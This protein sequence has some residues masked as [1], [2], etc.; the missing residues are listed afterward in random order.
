MMPESALRDKV[1]CICS[2]PIVR[3]GAT[4]YRCDSCN[5]NITEGTST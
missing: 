4:S 1:C 3:T 2:G 5:S